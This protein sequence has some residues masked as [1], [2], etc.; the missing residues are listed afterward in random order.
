MDVA[1]KRVYVKTKQCRRCLTSHLN[2]I[3]NG[4][5][6]KYRCIFNHSPTNIEAAKIIL[7]SPASIL[8]DEW[9]Q[10]QQHF[11]AWSLYVLFKWDV[12]HRLP[13]LVLTDTY[14]YNFTKGKTYP[15][16]QRWGHT[17][18]LQHPCYDVGCYPCEW[19][20]NKWICF[21]RFMWWK[22]CHIHAK[23]SYLLIIIYTILKHNRLLCTIMYM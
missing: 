5:A 6:Q 21:F 18:C 19:Q 9:L 4:H 7:V 12:R 3:L 8:V 11:W 13:C 1:N 23:K 15:V 10:W 22:K 2:R 20:C 16:N 14:L 17:T